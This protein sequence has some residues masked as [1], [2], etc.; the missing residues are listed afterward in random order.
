MLRMAKR[1][2]KKQQDATPPPP[3]PVSPQ[4]SA[5]VREG[6]NF[7]IWISDELG[8]AFEQLLKK[9]R[10]TKT[11]EVELM[12]E[13]ACGKAG[14]WPSPPSCSGSKPAREEEKPK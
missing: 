13:E 14:L 4:P 6:Y 5:R 11:A 9:T 12:I 2:N 10:R 3:P 8:A 7:N 1:T